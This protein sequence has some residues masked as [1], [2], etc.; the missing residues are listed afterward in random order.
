GGSGQIVVVLGV[1]GFPLAG[2][3][4]SAITS[5]PEQSRVGR[6]V[7]ARVLPA[8]SRDRS[9][10]PP[11]RSGRACLREPP[12]SCCGDCASE[13]PEAKCVAGRG[14]WP[15]GVVELRVGIDERRGQNGRRSQL[16]ATCS[17]D[18]RGVT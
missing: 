17:A 11:T 10:P 2:P 3:T 12:Q 5:I 14:R 15:S 18:M 6:S 16:N 9:S 1:I 13:G 4:C 7:Y 8:R